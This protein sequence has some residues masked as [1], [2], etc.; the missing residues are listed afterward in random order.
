MIS[1]E[2]QMLEK[3]IAHFNENREQFVNDHHG[4]YVVI[5]DN[6]E[7]GFYTD[8]LEAYLDAK[9]KFPRGSFLLRKCLRA[10]EE[11]PAIF[12]SRVAG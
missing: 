4:E 3:S 10:E 5:F 7:Q 8:K 9:S 12:R 6:A 11:A 1:Q 2:N